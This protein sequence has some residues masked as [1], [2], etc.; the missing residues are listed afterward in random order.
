MALAVR[1]R[2][3]VFDAD[4]DLA[5]YRRRRN[6]ATSAGLL[7]RSGVLSTAA[8]AS[9]DPSGG[10]LT[11]AFLDGT[12]KP[13]RGATGSTGAFG[14]RPTAPPPA[15]SGINQMSSVENYRSDA[16]TAAG[17]A[18]HADLARWCRSKRLGDEERAHWTQVLLADPTNQEAQSRLGMKPYLGGL[19]SYAQIDA[20]KKQR[21]ADQKDLSHWKGTVATC[22]RMIDSGS[23][24]ERGQAIREMQDTTDAT[25]VPGTEVGDR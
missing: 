25:V 4:R 24:T 3:T 7:A 21:A 19:L 22:K 6:D 14:N 2:S 13:I 20:I 23:E 18:A 12:P 11:G 16:L 9:V 8:K 5:E 15:P 17:I 1:R 10:E